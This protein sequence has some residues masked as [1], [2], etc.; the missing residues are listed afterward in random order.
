M[1][2]K[3]LNGQTEKI[4]LRNK[5]RKTD[6]KSRSKFQ[7]GIYERLLA[8]YPHDLIFEEVRVL[9]EG[10]I[11]DF[12]IPSLHLVIECHGR[13]HTRHIKHFHKTKQDFHHQQDIDQKKRDWC[14][15][16]NF[17]LTEIYDE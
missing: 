2:I 17:K 1:E 14:L 15:L 3:L 8:E 10:F 5:L 9:G 12:F 13:Q 16:N 6:G 4:K 7:A 11:L